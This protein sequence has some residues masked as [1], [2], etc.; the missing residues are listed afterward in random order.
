MDSIQIYKKATNRIK[1]WKPTFIVTDADV[2]V[3]LENEIDRYR[4]TINLLEEQNN[5]KTIA[6]E[7]SKG[8]GRMILSIDGTL[9]LDYMENILKEVIRYA[10]ESINKHYDR[11]GHN[12]IAQG[13]IEAYED[14][15]NKCEELKR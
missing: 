13:K 7:L 3:E 14:I 10:K 1:R 11:C 9:T 2:I 4:N 5:S 15:I 12:D 8:V 6:N